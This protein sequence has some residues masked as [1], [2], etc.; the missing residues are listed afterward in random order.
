MRRA[1][2]H[3]TGPAVWRAPFC[4]VTLTLFEE[5]TNWLP[6]DYLVAA[7]MVATPTSIWSATASVLNV[8]FSRSAATEEM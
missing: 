5:S 7:V 2:T 4:A 1:D 3:K 6:T 8:E